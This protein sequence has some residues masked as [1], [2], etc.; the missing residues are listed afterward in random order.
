MVDEDTPQPEYCDCEGFHT[1]ACELDA[2]FE[3]LKRETR[4]KF[5][6][7]RRRIGQLTRKNR[8]PRKNPGSPPNRPVG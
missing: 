8:G 5:E 1:G 7:L 3:A 6:A 2:K 4:R